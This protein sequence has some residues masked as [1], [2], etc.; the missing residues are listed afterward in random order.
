[1]FRSEQMWIMRLSILSI[2]SLFI[3]LV[4]LELF[5]CQTMPG[6]VVMVQS[7][8]LEEGGDVIPG[9]E[10]SA[11][12]KKGGK[13]GKGGGMMVVRSGGGGKKKKKG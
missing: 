5:V 4:G 1:M 3:L 10:K 13:K 9:D 12:C 11:A 7:E 8:G 6:D 2:I